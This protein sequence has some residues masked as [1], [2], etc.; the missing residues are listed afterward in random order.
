MD[1]AVLRGPPAPAPS[2]G[3]DVLDVLLPCSSARTFATR[4]APPIGPWETASNEI[5]DPAIPNEPTI[6]AASCVAIIRSFA[7]PVPDSP[8]TSS[9][10]T[11]PPSA[12]AIPDS[13]SVLV[14]VNRSSSSPW[15]SNPRTHDA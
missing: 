10:A 1:V 2:G 3:Q 6:W 7:G 12:I 4:L 13:I 9:S 14:R 5:S 11:S 8:S 15:A